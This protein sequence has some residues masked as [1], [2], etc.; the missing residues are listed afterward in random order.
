MFKSSI[1]NPKRNAGLRGPIIAI[2]VAAI[3]G[4]SAQTRLG[5]PYR[6]AG[7][8]YTL[9]GIQGIDDAHPSGTVSGAQ[10][11][12]D[13]E[14]APSIGVT[15]TSPKGKL[16]DFG[17]GLYTGSSKGKYESTG[18]MITYDAIVKAAT[19]N[20]TVMDFDIKGN[21]TGFNPRKV[22]PVIDVYGPGGIF[23]A[24][25]GPTE[26]F[27]V[28][29]FES[30]AADGTWSINMGAL[31]AAKGVAAT[32]ISAVRLSANWKNG[33]RASDPYL[34]K[35]ANNPTAVPEPATLC[36]LGLGALFLRRRRKV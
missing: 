20:V 22:T 7:A 23:L 12:R 15:Y 25:A 24:K 11:N 6:P 5:N 18:L 21:A 27:S 36:V 10:V 16:V 3:T 9:T 1:L 14:F 2:A 19:A 17:I 29:K 32:D 31:L 30:S 8:N 34:F 35:S 33:E 28:I 4:A 13:F 26:I